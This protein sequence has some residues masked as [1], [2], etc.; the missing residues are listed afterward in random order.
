MIVRIDA[1]RQSK[2]KKLEKLQRILDRINM[3]VR[4]DA[5]RQ[6]QK[7]ETGKLQRILDR[8]NRIVRIVACPPEAGQ[9][10]CH[11][12]RRSGCVF[13]AALPERPDVS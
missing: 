5:C 12:L 6:K 9:A 11:R 3:I 4:I 8:I 7:Q 10:I 1:C 13:Q 2:S